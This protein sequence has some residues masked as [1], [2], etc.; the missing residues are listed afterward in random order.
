MLAG[1]A[2]TRGPGDV[3]ARELRTATDAPAGSDAGPAGSPVA[4]FLYGEYGCPFTYVADA[5]LRSLA[6]PL[7]LRV[8][9][10]PLSARRTL[11]ADG[12]P[13]EESG[14]A[15]GEWDAAGRELAAEAAELGLPFEMPGFLVNT[16]EALQAAEFARDLGG[17][18]FG[19]LHRALFGAYF[20]EG[21]NLGRREVLLEVATEVGLDSGALRD[22]LEDGRYEEE[23]RLASEEAER[24][25]I[26]STP[27]MLFG[28]HEVVG[29]APARV[30]REA[31]R[32]AR[33]DG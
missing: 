15:P 27:T 16:H 17:G 26:E 23:L 32:R 22:A 11:P 14:H 20:A 21:R 29:C 7:G 28:R 18:A 13:V 30:M 19:R 2:R 31:A 12:L 1:S 9:W 5:R 3:G 25:G 8:R 6:G 24:Y 33:E 4:V 10:R